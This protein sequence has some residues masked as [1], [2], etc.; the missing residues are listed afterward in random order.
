MQ[1][2][3]LPIASM[4]ALRLRLSTTVD[5]LYWYISTHTDAEGATF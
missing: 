2:R 1:I 3:Q 5:L 4:G